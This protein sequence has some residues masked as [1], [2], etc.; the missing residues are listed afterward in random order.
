MLA[1]GGGKT[2]TESGQIDSIPGV[3]RVIMIL[4]PWFSVQIWLL[5]ASIESLFFSNGEGQGSGTNKKNQVSFARRTTPVTICGEGRM[6]WRSMSAL[7]DS[8]R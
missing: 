3:L 1:Q 2:K 5:S 4:R 6:P 7:L 8:C